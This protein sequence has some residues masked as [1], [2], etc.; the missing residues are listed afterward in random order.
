MVEI[1]HLFQYVCFFVLLNIFSYLLSFSFC[2]IAT[3]LICLISWVVKTFNIWIHF[4]IHVNNI[5]PFFLFILQKLKLNIGSYIYSSFT[6]W[7]I[8]QLLQLE[9]F[10][11]FWGQI[12]ICLFFMCYCCYCMGFM[13]YWGR[14]QLF[15]TPRTAACQAPLSFTISRSL[16]KCMSIESVMLSNRLIFCPLLLFLPSTFSSIRVFSNE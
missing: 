13:C 11:S 3:Q 5:S 10:S 6:L 2:E 16:F 8:Y 7:L 14:V 4:I 1:M 12:L 9:G 15:V